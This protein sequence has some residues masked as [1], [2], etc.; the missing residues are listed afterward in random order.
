MFSFSSLVQR[1][2]TLIDPTAAVFSSSNDAGKASSASLFRQ[3][4]RLPDTE[5]LLQEVTAELT[6]PA[7][8]GGSATTAASAAAAAADKRQQE[9]DNSFLG[10]LHLSEHFLCFSTQTTSFLQAS[11]AGNGIRT[12]GPSLAATAFIL[13]ICAVKQVDRL[14]SRSYTFALA[15]TLWSGSG[16]TDGAETGSLSMQQRKLVLEL[17][18]SR[19]ACQRFCDGLRRAQ[20]GCAK[21]VDKLRDVVRQCYSEYLMSTPS[22]KPGQKESTAPPKPSPGPP[23]AGLGMLFGYP[24]DAKKLRDRSKMRL[25]SEYF[26]GCSPFYAI[27][28]L[29]AG[30]L[31]LF[32]EAEATG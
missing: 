29:P 24:G 26:R 18:G 21:D 7:L 20:R 5:S 32:A 31:L 28:F 15:V 16:Q 14:H 17:T 9:G 1:A 19:P 25:W 6:L 8:H 23:D 10:W 3:Y 4:F 13:P 22:S 30:P 11:S 27:H 12:D 2:Q